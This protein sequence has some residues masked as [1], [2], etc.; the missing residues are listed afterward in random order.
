MVSEVQFSF[1][2]LSFL[3]EALP[4]QEATK[5][6]ESLVTRKAPTVEPVKAQDENQTMLREFATRLNDRYDLAKISE[7][8][9]QPV[10]RSAMIQEYLDSV[11][12]YSRD[13]KM[14]SSVDSALAEAM[15][16]SVGEGP[17]K[18]STSVDPEAIESALMEATRPPIGQLTDTARTAMFSSADMRG[19]DLTM[20]D[21]AREAQ[22]VFQ[23][24][25]TPVSRGEQPEMT[26]SPAPVD[27]PSID[28]RSNEMLDK[29]KGM[30]NR[31]VAEALTDDDMGLPDSRSDAEE[32][33]SFTNFFVDKIGGLE[34]EEDHRDPLGINTLGFGVLP[35]TARSLGFNP[36]DEGYQDRRVLAKAVYS[37]LYENAKEQYSEV[38]EGL[39]EDQRFGVLSLYINIG[40]LPEG[41]VNALSQDTP[42]FDAAKQSLASV[43]LAS[44]RDKNENRMKDK[45][46]RVIYTSSKGLSKRRA[47]EYNDLM[48]GQEGFKEVS[49]VSVEGTKKEPIFV[50]L[51]SDGEEVHRYKP[52]ISDPDKTYSGLDSSNS[53]RSISVG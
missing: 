34:G 14:R 2:A 27:A 10:V 36:D 26:D 49:T 24:M 1:D 32:N 46:G 16:G 25:V 39:N 3:K 18:F 35:E 47:Q 42:D 45:D 41:V 50:W 17:S 5:P 51:D 43:V 48:K 37:R 53:M 9:K 22:E 52:S 20:R 31:P 7:P 30:M 19:T 12:Q 8:P 13:E 21:N 4:E 11:E 33:L 28:T 23:P 15:Q 38:F 40:S 29:P 6:T 44:P